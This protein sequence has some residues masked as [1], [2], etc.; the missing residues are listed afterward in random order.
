MN[1]IPCDMAEVLAGQISGFH[2]YILSGGAP[3]MSYVSRNLCC[4]L[5]AEEDELLGGGYEAMVHPA[6]RGPISQCSGLPPERSGLP[7]GNTGS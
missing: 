2:Q 5:G 6:D 7:P 3:R 1:N 4:M